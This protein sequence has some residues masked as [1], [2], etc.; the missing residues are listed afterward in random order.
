MMR[1]VSVYNR[2]LNRGGEDEVFES[3]AKLLTERGCDVHLVTEQTQVPRNISH[4]IKM[5]IDCVWSSSWYEKFH[6]VLERIR[7]DIVHVHNVFPVMSPA[8]YYACQR[9]GVPVVQ[10]LH[11]YRLLC[12]ASTFYRN[13]KVCEE[14][15]N[16]SLWRGVQHGCFQDSRVK[17]AVIAAMLQVHRNKNTWQQKIDRYIALSEFA[18]SKFV[19]SGLPAEKIRVKPNFIDLDPGQPSQKRE[20]AIFVGRL[21]NW[22][23]TATLVSAWKSLCGSIPLMIVGDGPDLPQIETSIA[24]GILPGVVCKGRLTRNETITAIRA[25]RFLVFPSQWYEGFPM[26][27][28]EAFAC[29]VPVICS[30]LG[31]MQ[32]IVS[33][34]RTGLHFRAG[35]SEDLASKV[36]WAWEHSEEME[37]MGQQARAEFEA[38]YTASRNYEMLIDIY[39]EAIAAHA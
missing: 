35:D 20:Y 6:Q 38:K 1:I 17:T 5:A 39:Q 23:G 25:A 34:G 12:P 33:D 11:N 14:C 8:V 26:T 18:R 19:D 2:Y 29:S 37:I 10:T 15:V 13:D 32:E 24:Q 21:V 9:V 4:Q 36:R 31:S 3:E 16:H 22:K 28:A 30:G 7:P 27:I